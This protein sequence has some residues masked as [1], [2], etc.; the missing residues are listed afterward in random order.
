MAQIEKK[1]IADDAVD[2]RVLDN[3]ASYVIAGL[4][5]N[6]DTTTTNGGRIG[7]LQVDA[8]ELV[9]GNLTVEGSSNLQS[10]V[11]MDSDATVSGGML[12]QGDQSVGGQLFITADST[13]SNLTVTGSI[14]GHSDATFDG[15][16]QVNDDGT[17][18]GNVRVDGSMS[19]GS[20]TLYMD[21]TGL[22]SSSNFNLN[23]PHTTITGDS[24]FTGHVGIG[25]TV[26]TNYDPSARRLVVQDTT[27]NAGITIASPPSNQGHVFFA[28]GISGSDRYRGSVSYDH[29]LNKMYLGTDANTH[30]SIDHTG[31]VGV[32]VTQP[33]ARLETDGDILIP[34]N[35]AYQARNN[36]SVSYDILKSDTTG[37]TVLSSYG[38][39]VPIKFMQGLTERMRVH[40]NGFIG[41]ATQ[42]PTKNLHVQGDGLFSR[43]VEIG[44]DTT[45]GSDLVVSDTMTVFGRADFSSNMYISGSIDT[46]Q[47]LTELYLMNQNVRSSDS[48]AFVNLTLSG[49][50]NTGFGLTDVYLMNQNVR[51]VDS[52]TFN[53]MVLTGTIDTGQGATEVYLM[54]QHL[55]TVDSPSFNNLTLA[56]TINTGQGATEVY[57][58]NQP[59]Q[60]SDSPTF[61]NVTA[62]NDFYGTNGVSNLGAPSVRFAN[63]YL[64]STIDYAN[65]LSYVSGGASRVVFNTNGQVGIG[66]TN[67]EVYNASVYDLVIAK[68][69]GNA[70]LTI[71]T[72]SSSI[73]LVNFTD[74]LNLGPGW[75]GYDHADE[76]MRFGVDN[77]DRVTID[78]SGV[79]IGITDP[80]SFHPLSDDLVVTGTLGNAGMTLFSGG[81]NFGIINF[82]DTSNH[83]AGSPDTDLG[84]GWLVYDHGNNQMRFG[85]ENKDRMMIDEFGNFRTIY[86]GDP[87]KYAQFAWLTGPELLIKTTTNLG[88]AIPI[89]F[90]QQDSGGADLVAEVKSNHQ[91]DFK[92]QPT[93]NGNPLAVGGSI[94]WASSGSYLYPVNLNYW[95]GIGTATPETPLH[96]YGS[97]G[98]STY[99]KIQ[100]GGNEGLLGIETSGVMKL[101]NTVGGGDLI[102]QTNGSG[103]VGINTSN[104]EAPLHI[105]E[106]GSNCY[107]RLDYDTGNWGGLG[108][109]QNALKLLNTLSNADI[110][111]QTSGTGY[112]G[113]N[114]N[115]A[116]AQFHLQGSSGSGTY[117]R[118]QYGASWGALGHEGGIFRLFN[119]VSGGHLVLQ[120]SGA[121]YV[122]VNTDTVEAP[123]HI[124]NGVGTNTY[125][126]IQYGGNEGLFGIE[127]SGVMKVINTVSGADLVLQT[128]GAGNV[129]INT[130]NA[131]SSIHVFEGGANAYLRLD[132][133]L[134]NWGGVGKEQTALKVLNTL[135]GGDIILQTAGTGY[136]GVNTGNAEANVHV[137]GSGGSGTYLRLDHGGS[138]SA[139]GQESGNVKLFNTVSGG[140]IQLQTNG[141]VRMTV[142]SSGVVDFQQ[143]PTVGGTPITFGKW[144]QSGSYLYPNNLSWWVGIGTAAP[145]TRLHVYDASASYLR[146]DSGSSWGALGMENFSRLKLFNTVSGGDLVL[147]TS[148]TGGVGI[149]TDDA[150]N[151]VMDAWGNGNTTDGIKLHSSSSAGSPYFMLLQA[152]TAKAL[153]KFLDSG[154]HIYYY[155]YGSGGHYFNNGNLG[156]Y[157]TPD[158]T[159]TIKVADNGIIGAGGNLTFGGGGTTYLRAGGSN[160]VWVDSN[161]MAIAG[162]KAIYFVDGSGWTGDAGTNQGKIQYYADR[163]YINAGSNA[164][165]I[166]QFRYGSSDKSYIDINGVFQGTAS[167]ATSAGSASTATTASSASYATSAGDSDRCD[168]LHVN[169]VTN[170]SANR[171]I[172]TDASGYLGL[173]IDPTSQLHLYRSSGNVFFRFQSGGNSGLLGTNDDAEVRLQNLVNGGH[174]KMFIKESDGPE[175]DAVDM[176]SGNDKF[177]NSYLSMNVKYIQQFGGTIHTLSDERIKHNIQ[178]M[179]SKEVLDRI[180]QLKGMTYQFKPEYYP[181]EDRMPGMIAQHTETLFPDLVATHG[182]NSKG[183]DISDLKTISYEGFTAYFVEAIK[184]LKNENDAVKL[185]N[186]QLRARLDNI[187]S[188]LAVLEA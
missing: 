106:S 149:N 120:T 48:P 144:T 178:Y 47:G 80:R 93:Y 45:V 103:Y 157:T 76:N 115:D 118:I 156:V 122:G 104:A 154:E 168:G 92:Y 119:T 87:L 49:Q 90:E 152:G 18:T 59:V 40:S 143:T 66:T 146:L 83:S 44:R 98:T 24:G 111:I 79:G 139:L 148:G 187:E 155:N 105:H 29:F 166:V 57:L 185:E 182:Q 170:V 177:A 125:M 43:D 108:K 54:N 184:A 159:Y 94:K 50:I 34:N 42:S 78:S 172:R 110:L 73:G 95:V 71:R 27:G 30:L 46:G 28:D 99:T 70:G 163:F 132:Y 188:R 181:V 12:I 112:V 117:A 31:S 161:G 26:P 1:W 33:D 39:V 179:N 8:D 124:Y 162:S 171:I 116:Q 15:L 23:T 60:T 85:L 55:R 37:H 7:R 35:S 158:S 22:R 137:Y 11:Y 136:V 16:L 173:G 86:E 68:S 151:M 20:G 145:Q 75:V 131:Q 51:T 114:T 88:T 19:V 101:I 109:E 142:A 4:Q 2:N 13:L 14:Y 56:G 41:I 113:I 176:W 169:S 5:V 123:F 72:P 129:G 62:T 63:L 140:A 58:M 180:V 89:K 141:T 147:Q 77:A 153:W 3:T 165:R 52:P 128:S 74:G 32:G 91:W 6:G 164:N 126:K 97:S 64:N 84:P 67:P 186:E 127:T 150:G 17:F 38:T 96:V 130:S 21:G 100:Y 82:A 10:N 69:S 61:L 81:S 183:I 174:I 160:R 167:Y 25:T 138:W 133:D 102:L 65:K 175:F 53:S 121:G 135:N 36:I 107:L 134:N 9:K